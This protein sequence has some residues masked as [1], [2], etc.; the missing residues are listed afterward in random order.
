MDASGTID[1]LAHLAITAGA[2][3][4]VALVLWPRSRVRV[5]AWERLE[6]RWPPARAFLVGLLVAGV[7]GGLV[8]DYG[9]RIAT[10]MLLAAVPLIGTLGLRAVADGYPATGPTADPATGPAPEP[11]PAPRPDGTDAREPA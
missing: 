10:V 2:P 8:N 3:L 9:V 11:A 4:L 7:G 5:A 6:R 1:H